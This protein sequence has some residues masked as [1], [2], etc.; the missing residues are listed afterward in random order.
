[1][2]NIMLIIVYCPF[3]GLAS[4]GQYNMEGYRNTNR[5]NWGVKYMNAKKNLNNTLDIQNYLE[6]CTETWNT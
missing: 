6:I 4:V 2:V 1:M 5:S 3:S